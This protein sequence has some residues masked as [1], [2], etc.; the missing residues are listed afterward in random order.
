MVYL[1]LEYKRQTGLR[2]QNVS[3]AKIF[4]QTTADY[5]SAKARVNALE[6]KL[7]LIEINAEQLEKSEEISRYNQDVFQVPGTAI[8]VELMGKPFTSINV[9]F[10]INR[11]NRISLGAQ[12][13][14]GLIPNVMYYYLSGKKSRFE[15]GGGLSLIVSLVNSEDAP[16]DFQGLIIHGVIGYRYQKKNGLLF[17]IGFTPLFCPGPGVF[18]PM[19]GLSLGYS[20]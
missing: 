7:A 4:Q 11:S 18:L 15:I 16:N 10:R 19:V 8:Y 9:D 5:K 2:E 12:L 3:S 17:R 13:A 6:E 14:Y 20:F 1:E